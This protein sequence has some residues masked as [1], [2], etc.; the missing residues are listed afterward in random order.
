MRITIKRVF[1]ML[2]A[3]I[4]LTI[5]SPVVLFL[6]FVI[7]FNL[8]RPVFYNHIRAGKHGKP[9]KIFKLRTMK[10][11]RDAQG[12]LLADEHRLTALGVFLRRY[13]L[14][15]LPELLNVLL[16]NMSL[17]GPRPLLMR[18]VDR[19]SAEQKR[20]L[21]ALPGLTGW[22]QINGR[23]ELSWDERFALDVWY[24]DHK[25]F[26]LDIKILFLTLGK[27]L[28]KEGVVERAGAE[29]EEFWGAAGPPESG[30][31]A[32]P[33]EIDETADSREAVEKQYE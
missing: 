23:N 31:K 4:M 12:R 14:D 5:L 25:S 3:F 10:T 32:I 20:R 16:G 27:V 21:E 11:I 33:V 6:G 18:Y 22:A 9:F 17:V 29:L 24:V 8:G 13:S 1:D 2:V 15:E 30:V 26:W 19:Y 7:Y 28:N